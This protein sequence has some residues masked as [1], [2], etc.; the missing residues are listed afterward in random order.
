LININLSQSQAGSL[1][2]AFLFLYVGVWLFYQYHKASFYQTEISTLKSHNG[3]GGQNKSLSKEGDIMK[4]H[5]DGCMD[6][7][8]YV[9]SF[10][11]TLACACATIPALPPTQPMRDFK[12]LAGKWEGT[13]SSA[14]FGSSPIVMIIR[15][16]GT[17]ETIV[18]E[19]SGFFPYSDQG[20]F[21]FTQEWVEG[22][23][24]VKNNT[25][26]ETGIRTLQEKGG[27]RVLVY[28][29]DDGLTMAEYEQAQ[30]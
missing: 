6:W 7:R 8:I 27:K 26:G 25:S 19:S 4:Q 20:R 29:S 15:E 24:R 12:D 17:G 11:V 1:G 14:G 21:Y 5:P 13:I 22:K 9:I 30:K 3:P 10:V 2:S 28:R 23:I 16:D 18:P